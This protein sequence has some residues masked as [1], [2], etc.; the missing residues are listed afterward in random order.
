VQAHYPDNVRLI[1]WN[2][3][4][5]DESPK[6]LE[7]ISGRGMKDGG[8]RR[9]APDILAFR[10]S[11]REQRVDKSLTGQTSELMKPRVEL[12]KP[13]H[14]RCR[15]RQGHRTSREGIQSVAWRYARLCAVISYARPPT[16]SSGQATKA[17]PSPQRNSIID[18]RKKGKKC[19]A[20]LGGALI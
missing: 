18:I 15:I 14:D 11:G 3:G 9:Y 19:E 20:V 2:L 13:H 8:P 6:F 1:T 4:L 17:D 12:R 16:R 10:C 5:R 7:E